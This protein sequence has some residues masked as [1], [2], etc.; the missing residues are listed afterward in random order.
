MKLAAVRFNAPA[1][2]GQSQAHSCAIDAPLLERTEQFLGVAAREPPA[3]ILNLDEYAI[4]A[5][6][7]LQRDH[8][9][10]TRELAGVLQQ[11]AQHG[12]EHLRIRF[13]GQALL[14]ARYGQPNAPCV[15]VQHRRRRHVGDEGRER[16]RLWILD[17]TPQ[18]YFRER[19]VDQGPQCEETAV[20]DRA[21][22]AGDA[23]IASLEDFVGQNRGVHQ[24]PQ[25]MRE[26]PKT[27]GALGG[28]IIVRGLRPPAS[29]FGDG[30]GDR[31]IEALIQHAKIVGTDRGILLTR[32]FGDRLTD[33]PIVVHYLRHGEAA[34]QQFM[35]VMHGTLP[36]S[37]LDP[38][39]GRSAAIS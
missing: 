2:E 37:G 17:A 11:V 19:A 10:R 22:A 29:V 4:L 26:E 7:D 12:G 35:P 14:D 5:T 15:G 33:I 36:I 6:A 3:L 24:I 1:A 38:P 39:P 23:D 8:G 34:L 32:Q 30:A 31:L 18:L 16:D 9:V 13:D 21:G 25:F 27:F 20:E 28:G